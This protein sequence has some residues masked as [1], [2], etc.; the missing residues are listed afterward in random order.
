MF[1]ATDGQAMW[2]LCALMTDSQAKSGIW[3]MPKHRFA[4]LSKRLRRVI[5]NILANFVTAHW[6]RRQRR[7]KPEGKICESFLDEITLTAEP[8]AQLSMIADFVDETDVSNNFHDDP[9]SD[10]ALHVEETMD[11]LSNTK[12]LFVE[13]G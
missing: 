2:Q 12:F 13:E 7:G 1:S 4:S 6:G 5:G 9:N 10:L 8:F 11:F 3:G